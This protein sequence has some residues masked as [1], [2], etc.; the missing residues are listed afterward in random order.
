MAFDFI[1]WTFILIVAI[2]GTC[3]TM[4]LSLIH[5]FAIIIGILWFGWV[6]FWLVSAQV[7]AE[8]RIDLPELI[9]MKMNKFPLMIFNRNER[10]MIWKK[11]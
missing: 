9:K 6:L 3:V 7:F 5:P 2:T 10:K 1:G 11:N 8:Y 4:L